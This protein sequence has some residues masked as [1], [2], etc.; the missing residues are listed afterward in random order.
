M[1]W[2]VGLVTVPPSTLSEQSKHRY[3]LVSHVDDIDGCIVP[4][5][6]QE[7]K[8]RL[9]TAPAMGGNELLRWWVC[10]PEAR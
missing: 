8:P 10:V 3:S 5:C 7:R 6:R 2:I 4:E 9:T 1:L